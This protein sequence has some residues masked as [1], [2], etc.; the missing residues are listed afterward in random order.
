MEEE[1]EARTS[2]WTSAGCFSLFSCS[3]VDIPGSTL[4][5]CR[6]ELVNQPG[7]AF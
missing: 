7:Q 4:Q 6:A 3:R 1:E 5:D 2:T